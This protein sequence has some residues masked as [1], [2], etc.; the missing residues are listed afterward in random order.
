MIPLSKLKIGDEVLIYA[1]SRFGGSS[2]GWYIV[3]ELGTAA[4]AVM[5]ADLNPGQGFKVHEGDF[6]AVRRPIAVDVDALPPSKP[7]DLETMPASKLEPAAPAVEARP[8]RRVLVRIINPRVEYTFNDRD[9]EKPRQS[10]PTSYH[11]SAAVETGSTGGLSPQP[12]AV[13]EMDRSHAIGLQ[14]DVGE[15]GAEI[16]ADPAPSKGKA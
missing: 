2:T 14:G 4:A 15:A 1:P 5:P 7:L 12:F 9:P 3:V 8:R 11:L 6:V 16:V 13:I 10:I